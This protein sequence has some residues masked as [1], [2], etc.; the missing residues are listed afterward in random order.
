[1]PQTTELQNLTRCLLAAGYAKSQD[2][3][4][5]YI[6]VVDPEDSFLQFQQWSGNSLIRQDLIVGSVRPQSTAA[7]LN[8]PSGK[9]IFCISPSS[10]LHAYDYDEEQRE[11]AEND[12]NDIGVL[13]HP[14][15]KLASSV[16]A[17]GSV[18]VVFQ[19]HSQHL[20]YLDNSWSLT[21]LSVSAL[22]GSPLSILVIRDRLHIFYISAKDNVIHDVT[23]ANHSWQD[24]VV[25]KHVFETRP[26][27]FMMAENEG[28]KKEVYVMNED[29]TFLKIDA[30]GRLTKLGTV[31]MGK[32]VSERSVDLCAKDAWNGTLTERNLERYLADDPS[33]VDNPGSEHSVTPLAAACIRGQLDV[34]RLL[35]RYRADPNALSPKRRTPLFYT[36]ST[37]EGRNRPAIVRALLEAGANVDEC[38]AENGFNTPLMNA[39]TLI[40]DQDVVDELLNHGASLSAK[41]IAKQTVEMLAKGTP[42]EPLISERL[43]QARSDGYAI[44]SPTSAKEAPMGFKSMLSGRPSSSVP[45]P[46]EYTVPMLAEATPKASVASKRLDQAILVG[47]TKRAPTQWAPMEPG[48]FARFDQTSYTK[49]LMESVVVERQS[50][51]APVSPMKHTMEKVAQRMSERLGQA[52]SVG[53][54]KATMK[55]LPE[56]PSSIPVTVNHA[57]TTS[58]QEVPREAVLSERLDQANLSP[59]ENKIVE[60]VFAMLMFI[61]AYTNSPRVKRL[62]DQVVIGLTSQIND[63]DER[64]VP[65]L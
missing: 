19:D 13:V 44:P 34:V 11:W 53:Y 55:A 49:G 45:I 15:G 37:S 43:E 14:D 64:Y 61:V 29:N 7:Y 2:G 59:L 23:R 3:K 18:H 1:M 60:F 10:T 62:V 63:A 21:T 25:V 4:E 40:S 17:K 20:V 24:M 28:K 56:R 5:Q 35:L 48:V 36:T 41:D 6:L 33:C 26:K 31:M 12:K 27:S 54:N 39:I 22:A 16:D 32:F 8:T 52:S 51:S 42:I 9:F 65:V 58:A 50:S 57:R 46:M 47:H 38:Y 30:E